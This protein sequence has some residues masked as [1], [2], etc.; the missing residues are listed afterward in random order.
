[1]NNTKQKTTI[2]VVNIFKPFIFLLI[3]AIIILCFRYCVS[4]RTIEEY[5][6]KIRQNNIEIER[7][8]NIKKQLHTTAQLLRE[9]SKPNNELISGLSNKWHDCDKNIKQ[10]T[11]DN[12]KMLAK[13]EELSKPIFVGYFTATHYDICYECTGKNPGDRGYGVTAS[14]TRATPNRTVAVDPKVI[15]IGSEVII[16]GHTYIAEDTGG[17]IRGN[18]I[19]ICVSSHSEAIQKGRLYNVP[20]YIKKG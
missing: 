15:P 1:M 17:A 12:N 20:V 11:E 4:A 5:E 14:G 16:N 6:A 18:K 13:I 2:K 9:E 19:D 8:E 7:C 3:L 10:L